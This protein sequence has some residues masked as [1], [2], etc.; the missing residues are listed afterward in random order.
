MKKLKTRGEQNKINRRIT[1]RNAALGKK[2][3]I[4]DMPIK[5]IES[6]RVDVLLRFL[7]LVKGT[8]VE[9]AYVVDDKFCVLTSGIPKVYGE[10]TI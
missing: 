8:T 9:R 5:Y 3:V 7:S 2:T 10:K 6:G 4:A 1:K